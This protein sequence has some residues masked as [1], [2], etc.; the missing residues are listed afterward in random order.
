MNATGLC[1]SLL[2]LLPVKVSRQRSGA[3][4]YDY[5]SKMREGGN[6][7]GPL[8]ER[9]KSFCRLELTCFLMR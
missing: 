1:C 9:F 2:E 3:R 5:Y 7:N 4:K 6:E 8:G